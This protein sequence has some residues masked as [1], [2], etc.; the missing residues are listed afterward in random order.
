MS[1]KYLLVIICLLT[2][3]LNQANAVHSSIESI[4]I[5]ENNTQKRSLKERLLDAW[6]T[7]KL[8]NLENN[9]AIPPDLKQCL[10]INL[11]NQQVHKGYQV[12]IND[13]L[14]A[15]KKCNSGSEAI[16]E[17]TLDKI[18]SITST[19]GNEIYF[20]QPV[21]VVKAAANSPEN[22]KTHP[23]V[24]LGFVLTL[25]GVGAALWINLVFGLIMV[26]SGVLLAFAT[27]KLLSRRNSPYKGLSLINII[28][29]L[30]TGLHMWMLSLANKFK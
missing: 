3:S 11:K 25:G 20:Q 22:P 8:K 27:R 1:I 24:A 4:S 14:V 23:A 30:G 6:V 19:D 15:Y 29:G 26:M 5:S 18:E 2:T 12:Q 28:T 13:Q 10:N 7:K 17:V 21:Q 16:N 9:I